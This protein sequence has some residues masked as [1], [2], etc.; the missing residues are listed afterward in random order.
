MLIDVHNHSMPGVDDGSQDSDMTFQMLQMAYEEGIRAVI[1]TPHYKS[2]MSDETTQK[3]YAAYR[4]A[5]LMAEKVS[6]RLKLYLGEELYYD[7]KM[8]QRLREG[9]AL[10]LNGTQYVLA[11]FPVY[12]DYPYIRQAVQD[13]W[14][15]G[16]LP[17]L[18]HIERYE[19]LKKMD[20]VEEL[21]ELG[22]YIQVNAESVIGKAGFRTK[23]YLM[24]LIKKDLVHFV[25]TD[26]HNISS[27][28]PQMKACAAYLKK[29]AGAEKAQML[30]SRNAKK[31]LKGEKIGE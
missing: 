3:R 21:V 22:A 13:L 8:V 23:H 18:A 26:A 9:R 1:L 30:C 12:V 19:A 6:P 15:A 24:K 31:I 10:T 29:K 4:K 27:R 25:G 17:V 14:A 7:S 2:T 11:E 16:Y 20:H 28:P 5:C